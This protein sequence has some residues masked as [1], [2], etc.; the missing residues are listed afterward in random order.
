M[1]YGPALF[2]ICH[3]SDTGEGIQHFSHQRDR[4]FPLISAVNT[5]LQYSYIIMLKFEKNSN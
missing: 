4:F 3:F 1:V 2:D 5:P